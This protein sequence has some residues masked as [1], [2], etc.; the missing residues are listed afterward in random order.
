[1]IDRNYTDLIKLKTFDE[2]YR[3][4][5]LDGRV[6]ETTFGFHRYLNQQLYRSQKWKSI[7]NKVIIRDGACDLA[8]PDH[9]IIGMVFVHHMI[10]ITIEDIENNAPHVFDMEFLVCTSFNTHNAIHFGDEALL[11]KLPAERSPNDTCPWLL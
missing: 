4:L 10:P 5:R 8:V 1:M 9:E 2:R 11:P 7:R 3:Y 6:G